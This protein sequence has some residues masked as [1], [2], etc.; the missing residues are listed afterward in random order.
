MPEY[1]KNYTILV[2]KY[3]LKNSKEIISASEIDR[4]CRN[5]NILND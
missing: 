2:F 1:N 4:R 3:V 5:N